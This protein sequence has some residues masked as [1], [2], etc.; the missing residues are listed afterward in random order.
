MEDSIA[1]YITESYIPANGPQL[2]PVMEDLPDFMT[3]MATWL[4]RLSDWMAEKNL[5]EGVSGPVKEMAGHARTMTG[6]AE[7]AAGTF[8]DKYDFWLS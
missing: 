2:A 1:S 6:L 5:D 8:D 7:S 3:S 4:G